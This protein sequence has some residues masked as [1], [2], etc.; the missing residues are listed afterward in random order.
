MLLDTPLTNY[1]SARLRTSLRSDCCACNDTP[2][3]SKWHKLWLLSLV[4]VPLLPKIKAA[5]LGAIPILLDDLVLVCSILVG[6]FYAVFQA[7]VGGFCRLK[8][9]MAFSAL[10]IFFGYKTANLAILSTVYPWVDNQIGYGVF[11]SE[12]VLVIAK[13]WMSACV[14]LLVYNY[15]QKIDDVITIVNYQ[16]LCVCIVVV[17]GM[18]QWFVLDLK[19][20]TSTFRNLYAIKTYFGDIDP[21]WGQTGIGHEHLGAFL[22]L[23][24][25]FILPMLVY[26]WPQGRWVRRGLYFL[27]VG[28]LFCLIFASSRGAWIG[29]VCMLAAFAVLMVKTRKLL[30]FFRMILASLIVFAYLQWDTSADFISLIGDRTADLFVLSEGEIRDDSASH[31]MKMAKALWGVFTYYPLWGLGAGGAGRIAEGQYLRELVEGGIVGFIL[32]SVLIYRC[33][34][35]VRPFMQSAESLMCQVISIG[36]FCALVGM[37]G[38]SLFTELLII[39]KVSIPF[40]IW[41]A[42]AHRIV[43]LNTVSTKKVSP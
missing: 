39:T 29:A 37:L 14:Y 11:F 31:R 32:F 8:I 28:S 34:E 5:S 25:S 41:A 13:L 35:I 20:I 10:M 24:L 6:C 19:V 3:G 36:F 22:V 23:S 16:I 43:A 27:L 1:R 18:A 30:V 12:G 17:I 40:W 21:W 15:I 38:Q 26:R 4:S 7:A 33:S 9:S 42:S 2:S